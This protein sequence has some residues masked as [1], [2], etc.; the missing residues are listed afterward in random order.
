MNEHT[1]KSGGLYDNTDHLTNETE[2]QEA[3]PTEVN[4][5]VGKIRSRFSDLVSFL[6]TQTLTDQ[7]LYY[8]YNCCMDVMQYAHLKT[9]EI[10][11][12]SVQLG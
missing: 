8:L 5:N 1:N 10:N 6:E 4:T 12:K 2:T 7:D 3:Q 11:E 9:K